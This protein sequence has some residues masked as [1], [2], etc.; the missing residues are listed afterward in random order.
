[1]L[2]AFTV[3]AGRPTPTVLNLGAGTIGGLTFTPGLYKW[4]TGVTIPTDMTISGA[5]NDTWTFQAS[6]DLGLSSAK[7]ITLI[8]GARAKNIVWQVAGAVNLGTT[9]HAEGV[10]PARRR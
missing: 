6:G 7:A 4:T 5:P 3:A 8:G 1:M 9:L 10:I 2:T